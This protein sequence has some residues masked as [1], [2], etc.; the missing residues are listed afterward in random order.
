MTKK[1]EH[2]EKR[3]HPL[4]WI[5]GIA[6]L[7]GALVLAGLYWNRT[8]SIESI[9]FDGY[10]YVSLEQLQKQV[11]IPEGVHPDSL[12]Y[13]NVIQQIK[14]IPN[15][16]KVDLKIQPGGT[17]VV[18]VSERKP[19]ALLI[20]NTES[21]FVDSNG[22][23]LQLKS[24][25]VPA[26]PILYGFNVHSL[27]DTLQSK[28]FKNVSAFLQMLMNNPASNATISE[29]AWSDKNGVIALTNNGGV[30]L[31]F[32]KDN[33]QKRLRNWEAFYAQVIRYKGIDQFKSV[34]LKFAGQIV[35]HE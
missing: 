22:V 2:S 12:N 8:S 3:A 30:K 26:V 23:K 7:L 32:G 21:C 10:E 28:A 31:V 1:K 6:L 19:I 20:N 25:N 13:D 11:N 29:V 16:E 27:A 17:M 14:E 9:E 4:P 15:I 35:T 33:Y 34:N 24:E 18:T 5:A